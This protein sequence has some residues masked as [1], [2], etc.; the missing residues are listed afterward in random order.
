MIQLTTEQKKLIVT[1]LLEQRSKMD[2]TDEQFAKQYD[3]KGAILSRLK[4]G[5]LE[6]LI[7]NAKYVNIAFKLNLSLKDRK[8]NIARTALLEMIEEEVLFCQAHS[9]GM[10]FI[11]DNGLGKSTAAKYLAKNMKNCFHIECKQ[12]REKIQFIRL[13]AET[14]GVEHTGRLNDLKSKIKYT[15]RMI[16]N[17]VVI[18]DDSG[19]LKDPAYMEALEIVD[20]TEGVCGWYQ[21]G[22]HT[23]RMKMERAMQLGKV[24][25]AAMF[26]RF[27]SNWSQFTS[28]DKDEKVNDLKA[29]IRAVI[30]VNSQKGTDVNHIINRTLKM[31]GKKVTGD[32]RRV[33]SLL[34]TN[35]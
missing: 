8:W 29:L 34:I 31:E 22:D 4:N 28:A 7:S 18:L 32:L 20:A 11:D 3:I 30:M 24:G 35:Q 13:L 9:K 21:I 12:G 2:V 10:I 26:S 5:E 1:A 17:P 16:P 15:L 25:Y 6:G 23:L 19:Y 33:E 27:A 14:I